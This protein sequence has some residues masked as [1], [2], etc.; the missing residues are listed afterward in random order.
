V[1]ALALLP[2]FVV[3]LIIATHVV[4]LVRLSRTRPA[5]PGLPTADG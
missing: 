5:P 1:A 3:P 4:M 2:T